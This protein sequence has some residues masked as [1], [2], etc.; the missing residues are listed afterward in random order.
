MREGLLAFEGGDIRPLVPAL[1]FWPSRTS[2]S[3]AVQ[4]GDWCPVKQNKSPAVFEVLLSPIFEATVN[5]M[6]YKNVVEKR[7]KLPQ[8]CRLRYTNPNCL[9]NHNGVRT[10]EP[11][12]H[13]LTPL[14][15][16]TPGVLDRGSTRIVFVPQSGC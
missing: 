11:S 10:C 16:S 15:I 3:L 12:Q 2:S 7:P 14:T 9:S 1:A 8:Q 6:K 4:L 13:I 5:S